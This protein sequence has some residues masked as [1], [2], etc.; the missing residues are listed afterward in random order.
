MKRTPMRLNR[1]WRTCWACALSI[2]LPLV[3]LYARPDHPLIVFASE[4]DGTQQL[5]TMTPDGGNVTNLS[6]APDDEYHSQGRWSPDGSRIAYNL[7]HVTVVQHGVN[8]SY[9]VGVMDWDGSD[10]REIVADG[11]QP[12]WSPDGQRLAYLLSRDV[13]LVDPDIGEPKRLTHFAT[14][15]YIDWSPN[16]RILVCYST[17]GGTRIES[18]DPDTGVTEFILDH[19]DKMYSP[20][21]SPDGKQIAFSANFENLDSQTEYIYLMTLS[22]GRIERFTPVDGFHF[23]PRWSP[24][25]RDIVFHGDRDRGS[26]SDIYRALA[27]NP[28]A[29][30]N[31]TNDPEVTNVGADWFDPSL[32]V[33][34]ILKM[35]TVW[36][37]LKRMR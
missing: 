5:F 32:S 17:V 35:P 8:V 24:D 10:Q 15:N 16:D 31:L 37:E 28:E 20:S 25:G 6:N 1:R 27:T 12:A 36:G 14:C 7:G 33:T 34:P 9:G 4:R 30:M 11:W 18:V 21:W 3:S 23:S 2:F 19:A 13:Y 26:R 22:D 29:E